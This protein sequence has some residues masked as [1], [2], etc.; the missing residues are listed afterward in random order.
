MKWGYAVAGLV[1]AAL[2][3]TRSEDAAAAASST[4]WGSLATGPGIWV[5]DPARAFV[6]A[7]T[8]EAMQLAATVAMAHGGALQVADASRA[9]F[10]EPFP[11]HTSHREGRDVDIGY[12]LQRVYPTPL[13]TIADAGFAAVLAALA[14]RLEYVFASQSRR[15]ELLGYAFS[16]GLTLPKITVWPG[17]EQ[18]AHL[19][20]KL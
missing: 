7:A 2:L 10:G 13:D 5:R 17:H 9:I 16:A 12:T 4:P 18:H 8:A 6:T 14:D 1:V 19:R 3:V 11:P 15:A 20:F